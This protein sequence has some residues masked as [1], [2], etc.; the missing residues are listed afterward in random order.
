MS[1]DRS[2]S[3]E[4]LEQHLSRLTREIGVRLA[5]SEGERLA[6]EYIAGEFAG[7]GAAVSLE[8]YEIQSRVVEKQHLLINI[9]GRWEE[10][11][12]S[13][14]SNTP[15]TDGRML[16]APLVFFEGTGSSGLPDFSDLRGRA[17]VHL[18]THIESRD[19]YRALMEA[20][21]AFLLMVDIRYPGTIPL[22]DGMFP[23][24]TRSIGAVPTV[25]AAFMDAWRWKAE[26][27]TAARLSV[28]GGMQ[29]GI[30]QNVIA[31][32][33]GTDPE[34]GLVIIGAHH[35]TQADSVGA[36]DNAIGVAGLLEL[37]RVLPSFKLKRDIR[38]ISF[39]TEE[40]LSVGSAAY[41]RRHR[42]EME[43]RGL[44]MINLDSYGSLLGWTELI[45]NGPQKL[46]DYACGFY[47]A[48]GQY[49]KIS[50]KIEPYADHFPFV[51]AGVCGLYLGRSNCLGGRFFHHRPDDNMSRVSVRIAASLLDCTVALIRD[52]CT[53]KRP[54]KP[55]IPPEE[56]QAVAGLWEDLFGGWG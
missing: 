34:A 30:S 49:V 18:G 51:A 19:Y 20:E 50:R 10:F 56:A 31:D 11:P 47:E 25:N 48:R 3:P 29:P 37:A 39:G 32:L 45:C 46:A 52:A 15:G 23:A 22:A 16:E 21:P 1:K 5:G 24:Y 44:L 33:P 7:Y 42:Q 27:A 8:E 13:L 12:C 28:R 40:Q 54:F 6:A 38:L 35:D 55:E 2:V 4:L 14:F 36:D 9:G 41:V 43:E 53:A 17:V 26:E